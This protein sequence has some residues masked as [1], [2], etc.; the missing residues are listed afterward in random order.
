MRDVFRTGLSAAVDT[1]IEVIRVEAVDST[2][3]EDGLEE[4]INQLSSAGSF[5]TSDD[6]DEDDLD[7]DDDLDDEDEYRDLFEEDYDEDDELEVGD[8]NIVLVFDLQND[9]LNDLLDD[10]KD[11]KTSL[12]GEI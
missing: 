6:F 8:G 2:E 3:Y 10:A 4:A 12:K 1:L 11:I 7:L 9:D 5:D